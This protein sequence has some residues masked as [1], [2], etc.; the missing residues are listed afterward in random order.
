[1]LFSSH[2]IIVTR[3]SYDHSVEGS[4]YSY[5]LSRKDKSSSRSAEEFIRYLRSK[6]YVSRLYGRN[7]LI[8]RKYFINSEV[9]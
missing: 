1:M 8:G 3:E 4:E 6:I 2:V 7:H 9:K 5:K